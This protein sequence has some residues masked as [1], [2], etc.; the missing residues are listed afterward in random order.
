MHKVRVEMKSS[1]NFPMQGDVQVDEFVVGGQE[2][3]K[4]GR[5]YDT[6]KK[7]AVI[8]IELSDKGGLKRVYIKQIDSYSAKE[9]RPIFD[10]HI[11]PEASITT[12]QWKGYRPIAREF[13]ITQIPSAKG[14]NFPLL[15][16]VI[17]K[18][19]S[20]I[21]NTYSFVSSFHIERYFDEYCFRI[22]RSIHKETI[23]N[24]FVTRMV[25]APKIYNS[26]LVCS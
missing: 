17:H 13:N 6:K 25:K 10:E 1:G 20:W 24:N 16:T 15:H 12:D 18:V 5:S 11:A 26:E 22:N 7:K 14:E 9:L 3:G 21:R 8:A 4:G 2:E 23:F 19:K